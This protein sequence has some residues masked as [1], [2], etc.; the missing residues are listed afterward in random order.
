MD[1]QP[2]TSAAPGAAQPGYGGQDPNTPYGPGGGPFVPGGPGGPPWMAKKRGMMM[3]RAMRHT[4][5]LIIG[6]TALLAV[7]I[8]ATR[9]GRRG[10]GRG[11]GRRHGGPPQY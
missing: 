2:S 10:G 9:G 8:V 4:R 5:A 7:L 11:R 6:S 3:R 1:Q